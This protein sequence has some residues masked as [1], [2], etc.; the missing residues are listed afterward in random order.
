M[1][2]NK[3]IGLLLLCVLCWSTGGFLIKSVSWSPLAIS[4][5]RSGF[6]ALFLWLIYRP[7]KFTWDAPQWGAGLANAATMTLF[8][9]AT[10]LT[11]SANAIFLQYTAPLYVALFSAWY[12][13]EKL[14]RWDW[15]SLGIALFGMYLFFKDRATLS[16]SW[17][18]ILACISAVTY[19]WFTMFMRN[20]KHGSETE[21]LF[22]GNLLAFLVC[23]YWTLREISFDQNLL[24]V[25]AT[26][27]FQM[28]IPCILYPKF[29]KHLTAFDVMT[30][31]LLEPILNPLWVFF[32]HEEIPSFYAVVG[33]ACILSVIF[34]RSLGKS[35]EFDPEAQRA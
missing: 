11:T 17:G 29:I 20:H 23:G 34:F 5:G 12:L 18:E 16:N 28:T 8:V 15:I 26:A 31:S 6:C 33:G 10:K 7:F 3:A 4:G 21:S 14:S 27:A 32:F 1:S 13:R 25:A 35:P 24:W 2:R 9:L 19:A 30:I 22:L